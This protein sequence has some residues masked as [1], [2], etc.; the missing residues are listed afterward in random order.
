MPDAE[1]L[2]TSAKINVN[3]N[4]FVARGRELVFDGFTK[5]QKTST[6]DEEMLPT[7][8]EG[9]ILILEKINQEQK[10]TKPPARFSEAALVR[11]LEKKGIG[12]P[13]TYANIISTIQDR[14]Y[15]EIQN[16]RFFVKKI[17][18]IVAERLLESFNDI[19]DYDFTA[20]L[21]NNL[22]KVANGEAEWRNVLDGFY[23]SFQEDLLKCI[24]WA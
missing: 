2:S 19:M 24:G 20:N 16:K 9:E 1:Y 3:E 14:G 4:I 7:L 5:V 6:K 10:F 11:E 21:E 18:H 12:R 17:G 8:N 13:S 15:V 23:K 22:D